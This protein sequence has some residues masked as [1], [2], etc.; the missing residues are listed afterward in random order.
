MSALRFDPDSPHASIATIGRHIGGTISPNQ[1]EHI[2]AVDQLVWTEAVWGTPAVFTRSAA[3]GRLV[4]DCA[5]THS[6]ISLDADILG[7]IPHVAGT[8]VS[9]GQVLGRVY[10]LGSIQAVANY[11]QGAV[12]LEQI[13]DAIDYAQYI[14][15][16]LCEPPEAYGR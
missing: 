14:I 4:K 11:Y 7:G 15:E 8:R 1:I 6:W 5:K 9:V 2:S 10:A 13:K 16:S 12:S 3:I